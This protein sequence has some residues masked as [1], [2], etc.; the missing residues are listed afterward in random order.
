[1]I[2]E[3]NMETLTDISQLFIKM[4]EKGSIWI[5]LAKITDE[6]LFE[7]TIAGMEGFV[8]DIP[9]RLKVSKSIVDAAIN[10]NYNPRSNPRYTSRYTTRSTTRSTP[11]STP[12]KPIAPCGVTHQVVNPVPHHIPHC[13]EHRRLLLNVLRRVYVLRKYYGTSSEGMCRY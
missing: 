5:I 11:S 7:G 6:L 8:E 3:I 12:A 4:E 2:N 1:M 9:G 13:V 10:I